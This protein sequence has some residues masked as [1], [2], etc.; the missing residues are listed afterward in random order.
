MSNCEDCT[1]AMSNPRW[2]G[3]HASCS[4]C[5]ARALARSPDSFKSMADGVMTVGYKKALRD[6]FGDD[7]RDGHKRVR[8]WAARID[9]AKGGQA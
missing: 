6:V 8:E 2:G 1:A 7:W 4:E 3:Y 5:S 9:A